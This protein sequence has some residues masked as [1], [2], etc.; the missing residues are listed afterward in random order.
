MVEVE[1]AIIVL[2]IIVSL[3]GKQSSM[4][5]PIICSLSTFIF[6]ILSLHSFCLSVDIQ[7]E[8][9]VTIPSYQQQIQE[10][11]QFLQNSS[12]RLDLS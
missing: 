3:E 1:Q 5:P 7:V 4:L 6:D 12:F 9:V 11:V 10:T 2:F 8:N